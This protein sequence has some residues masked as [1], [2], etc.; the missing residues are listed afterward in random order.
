M[1]F[2]PVP[3]LAALKL[4]LHLFTNAVTPYGLSP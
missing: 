2:S 4:G 1:T 3:G